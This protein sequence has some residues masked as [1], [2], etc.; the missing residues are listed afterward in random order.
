MYTQIE[1]SAMSALCQNNDPSS[2][3]GLNQTDPDELHSSESDGNYVPISE[4]Y[5]LSD[6]TSLDISLGGFDFD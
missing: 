5:S 1:Q 4:N 3:A 6:V 2:S